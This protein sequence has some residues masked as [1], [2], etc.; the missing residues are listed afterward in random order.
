MSQEIFLIPNFVNSGLHWLQVFKLIAEYCYLESVPEWLYFCNCS[1]FPFTCTCIII[2]EQSWA[3]YFP[4]FFS[5]SNPT[6]PSKK[7]PY[8][9]LALGKRPKWH[10]GRFILEGWAPWYTCGSLLTQGPNKPSLCLN[11]NFKCYQRYL[12]RVVY[13]TVLKTDQSNTDLKIYLR[14]GYKD[15]LNTWT[16]QFITTL[17]G[18][19]C[20]PS[21]S[22]LSL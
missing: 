5:D 1:S 7:I 2:L 16:V 8:L 12:Y 6:T 3:Y 10:L 22:T 20:S 11:C 4:T 14:D 17:V 13:R 9:R 18:K 15:A 21:L 19:P